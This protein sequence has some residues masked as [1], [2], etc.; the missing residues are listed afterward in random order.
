MSRGPPAD[1]IEINRHQPNTIAVEA[2]GLIEIQV[3]DDR[4]E[5][6][7][8]APTGGTVDPVVIDTSAPF[9]T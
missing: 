2:F 4:L 7:F 6:S 9:E 8:C 3:W 1:E 5:H